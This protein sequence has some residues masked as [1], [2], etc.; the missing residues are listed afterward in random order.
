MC[1]FFGYYGDMIYQEEDTQDIFKAYLKFVI[2]C[3]KFR[4]PE[5]GALPEQANDTL[6]FLLDQESLCHKLTPF[7]DEILAQVILGARSISS[8]KLF[9]TINELVNKYG[10]HLRNNPSLLTG[11]LEVL[12][13]KVQIEYEKLKNGGNAARIVFSRSWNI[14]REIARNR[15]YIAKFQAEIER[16]LTPLFVYLATDEQVPFEED[17]LKYMICVMKVAEGVSEV[18]WEIFKTFPKLL[19]DSSKL[20]CTLFTALN[21]VIIYGR[22]VLE[23]D[24]D[25]VKTLLGM[26][27]Y[28]LTVSDCKGDLVTTSKGSLLLQLIIE[29]FG[30]IMDQ[31][32]EMLVVLC[33]E[34]IRRNDRDFIKTR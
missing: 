7:I 11:I 4:G 16:I 25:A 15:L 32:W 21:Y 3:M 30:N 20:S 13:E 34:I 14:F 22:N 23:N 1:L 31:D 19:R 24:A 26:G 8:L 2:E 9:D 5:S 17:I 10:H 29:N 18:C 6:T 33:V 28:S 12:V 27:T